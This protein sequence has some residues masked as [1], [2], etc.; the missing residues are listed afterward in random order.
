[1]N[2]TERRA[3][4]GL[5]AVYGIRMLGLFLI[6]PVFALYAEGLSGATPVLT[7]VAI[8]IYGLTQALGSE[9]FDQILQL[10]AR[11]YLSSSH[12]DLV[13][14]VDEISMPAR[15]SGLDQNPGWMPEMGR[16]VLFHFD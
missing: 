1:M 16:V 13:T 15:M 12:I 4:L 10:P 8:G 7:G 11:I 9:S 2:A 5:A 14:S 3:S 6:L